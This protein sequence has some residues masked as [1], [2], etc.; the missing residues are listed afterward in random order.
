MSRHRDCERIEVHIGRIVW[1][2]DG[3]PDAAA[4]EQA[5]GAALAERLGAQPA[6]P[7]LRPPAAAPSGVAQIADRISQAVATATGAP[8]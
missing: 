1:H 4:I 5:I 2:G 7:T 3:A 6:D 8:P